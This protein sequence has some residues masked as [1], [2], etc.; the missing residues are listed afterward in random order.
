M[1]FWKKEKR[2]KT[3]RTWPYSHQLHCI[4]SLSQFCRGKITQEAPAIVLIWSSDTIWKAVVVSD[5]KTDPNTSIHSLLSSATTMTSPSIQ[6]ANSFL[7]LTPRN[8]PFRLSISISLLNQQNQS[9]LPLGSAKRILRFHGRPSRN[10]CTKAVISQK[11]YPKVGALSTG[12]VPAAQ[13][14][15]V[16][17]AAAKTGAQV[18]SL[19]LFLAWNGFCISFMFKL[20]VA[21]YEFEFRVYVTYSSQ[22]FNLILWSSFNGL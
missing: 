13:L 1:I 11:H 14:I 6:M 22:I 18:L 5:T 17:E 19:S 12:P 7:S 4:I 3:W 10:L 15:Q 16:V 2:A 20:V 21:L 8:V 9:S